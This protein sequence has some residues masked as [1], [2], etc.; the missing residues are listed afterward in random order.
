MPQELPSG[1]NLEEIP[2]TSRSFPEINSRRWKVQLAGARR[3]SER[4]RV[5]W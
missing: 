2:Q 1:V 4:G 5:L 3:K